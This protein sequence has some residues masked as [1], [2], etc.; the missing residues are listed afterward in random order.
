MAALG[1]WFDS[2][3]ASVGMFTIIAYAAAGITITGLLG[4]LAWRIGAAGAV[5]RFFRPAPQVYHDEKQVAVRISGGA[6]EFE[7]QLIAVLE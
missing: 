6:Y 3:V 7:V 1:V 4:F 2:V 5:V